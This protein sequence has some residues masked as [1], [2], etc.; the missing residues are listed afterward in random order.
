MCSGRFGEP[1]G[2][3]ADD[4][5]GVGSRARCSVFFTVFV[6]AW[7]VEVRV[8]VVVLN[9]MVGLRGEERRIILPW[10]TEALGMEGGRE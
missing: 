2:R 1:E 9:V 8:R 6:V 3:G 10:A 5:V 7:P 4:G